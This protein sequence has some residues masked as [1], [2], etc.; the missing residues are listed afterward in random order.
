[1]KV[2]EIK[3]KLKLIFGFYASFGDRMNVEN[4][5]SSKFKR[6][7]ADCGITQKVN[8]KEIDILFYGETQNRQ[9]MPF[10]VFLRA[11]TR[12]AH[13]IYSRQ[14]SRSTVESFHQLLYEHLLPIWE[15][16]M[17]NPN[18]QT[19]FILQNEVQYDE[20]LEFL[21]KKIGGTLFEIWLAYFP[22][23]S[24][25]SRDLEGVKKRSEKAFFKFLTEFDMCP[26]FMSKTIAYQ[27]WNSILQTENQAFQNV[28]RRICHKKKKGVCF[29]FAK[30][31]DMLV[32]L[33][34]L[35]VRKSE[36]LMSKVE[37]PS[38]TFLLLL[39]KLELS[40]GFLTLE[41]KTNKPHVSKTSLLPPQYGNEISVIQLI[42]E[43]RDG[44]MEQVIEYIRSKSGSEMSQTSKI[45]DS[46]II[47]VQ[48]S[49]QTHHF[50]QF[51][52]PKPQKMM[53]ED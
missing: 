47:N 50:P 16:I 12:L 49:I 52:Q 28:S 2:T 37:L 41:K 9:N 45:Q 14:G 39:E 44:N 8:P 34:Y 46:K 19:V 24:S 21:I 26:D 48:P 33:A 27:L 23:E 10:D 7:M 6:M 13:M 42:E 43:A 31:I 11:L 25:N 1:M 15:E 53:P 18:Q 38:E 36:H 40:K 5:K 32:K 35:Y 22:W 4:L 30:F 20:L 51:Y 3:S 17:E 29:T